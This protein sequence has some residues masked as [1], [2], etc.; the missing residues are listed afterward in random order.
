M[1]A[2]RKP[3]RWR[4]V[5][6]VR[7]ARKPSSAVGS[8]IYKPGGLAGTPTAVFWPTRST[9]SGSNPQA[10]ALKKKSDLTAPSDATAIN[11]AGF[12]GGWLKDANATTSKATLW[13][14]ASVYVLAEDL[15][16][17]HIVKLGTGWSLEAVTAIN[18]NRVIV[19]NG[20]LNGKTRG[21]VMVP[22]PAGN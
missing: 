19:G 12:I 17:P 10:L 9:P 6:A 8:A 14:G 4:E 16:D 1:N 21:F 15:N 11:D 2:A 3:S 7:G 22:L 13:R 18:N 20:K 5:L